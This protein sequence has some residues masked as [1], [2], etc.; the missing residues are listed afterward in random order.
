MKQKT[1][2]TAKR[3]A[4]G[5]AGAVAA[6][7]LLVHTAVADPESLLK[8]NAQTATDPSHVC[9]VDGTEQR[10]YILEADEDEPLTLR[11]RICVRIQSWPLPVRA[12]ILLPLWGIGE[13]LIAL[14]TAL[15]NSPA[16]RVVLHFLLEAALLI[17]LF[18]LVW[19]LL[20]PHVPLR[21]VL[22]RKT[23][24]WLIAGALVIT[25]ADA[26][27]AYFWEDWK[28]WRIVLL[29]VVGFVVLLVLYH[30]IAGKLPPPERR[31]KRYE[32]YVE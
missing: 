6:A 19:K 24:P 28:I 21:R 15:W 23:F 26:L 29:A 7:G 4:A 18:A 17:G 10:S 5:A 20:F 12:L 22:S 30:R 32:V 8:P 1:G 9:V 13:L 3:V 16:G 31:K 11:E 25:V 14:F 27:L 2:K